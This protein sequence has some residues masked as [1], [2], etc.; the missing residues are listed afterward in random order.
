[1]RLSRKDLVPVLAIVAGGALGVLTSASLLLSSG[2]DAPSAT[3][4]S[5]VRYVTMSELILTST[6]RRH[7]LVA[8]DGNSQIADRGELLPLGVMVTDEVGNP[9]PEAEV[10]FEVVSG[11]GRATTRART[12][13]QGQAYAVWRLGMEAGTQELTATAEGI[14][15]VVTFTATARARQDS[16]V[17]QILSVVVD[18]L[19]FVIERSWGYEQDKPYTVALSSDQPQPRWGNRIRPS[20]PSEEPAPHDPSWL[21]AQLVKSHV[22]ATCPRASQ[23]R[24]ELGQATMIVTLSAPFIDPD[25]RAT[26]EVDIGRPIGGPP[27]GRG[28][29]H[30]AVLITLTRSTD[31]WAVSNYGLVSIT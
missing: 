26:V 20:A 9:I 22:L 18:Y 13:S 14:E 2:D 11:G 23:G 4:E 24:C 31:T 10:R 27:R 3:V 21:A 7:R 6:V 12:D 16:D 15:S 25:G 29:F 1:M 17:V 8:V 30:A 19:P 28:A 5:T